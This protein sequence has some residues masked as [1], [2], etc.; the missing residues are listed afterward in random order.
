MK[1]SIK[2][3][4]SKYVQIHRKSADLVPFTEEILNGKLHFLYC[5]MKNKK[6]KLC[7]MTSKE[8]N[9]IKVHSLQTLTM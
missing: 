8:F 1:F 5:D 3:F 2:G 9:E 7:F 6:H 4:F